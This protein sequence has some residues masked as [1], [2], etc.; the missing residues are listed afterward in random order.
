MTKHLHLP[1]PHI[2]DRFIEQI[3]EGW[4]SRMFH[5]DYQPTPKRPVPP[6]EDWNDWHWYDGKE[7]PR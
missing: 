7:T 5:H 2:A 1:H 6:A 4:F 3:G